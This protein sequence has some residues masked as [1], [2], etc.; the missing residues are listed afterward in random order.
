MFIEEQVEASLGE[1]P[2]WLVKQ[3]RNNNALENSTRVIITAYTKV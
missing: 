3:W 2:R 1:L